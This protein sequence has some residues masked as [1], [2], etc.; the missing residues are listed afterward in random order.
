MQAHMGNSYTWKL[1]F[2]SS[3]DH[4]SNDSGPTGLQLEKNKINLEN[5]SEHLLAPE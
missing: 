2:L 3:L 1:T 5:K 4:S